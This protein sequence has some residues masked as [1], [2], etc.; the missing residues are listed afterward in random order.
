MKI[1]EIQIG[2]NGLF[3]LITDG[4]NS[5]NIVS[6]SIYLNCFFLIKDVFRLFNA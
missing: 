2:F 3:Y 6:H 4:G 5:N 1:L